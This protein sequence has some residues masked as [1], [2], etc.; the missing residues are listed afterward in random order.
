VGEELSSALSMGES[1]MWVFGIMALAMSSFIIF[2]TFRTVVAERR[3]DLGM[4]RAI[5]ASKQT[6]MGLI[7]SNLSSRGSSVQPLVL[8]WDTFSARHSFQ[9]WGTCS[10]TCYAQQSAHL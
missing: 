5:G 4:L 10:R 7:L 8:C 1:M 9:V 3:R 2:N 6:I